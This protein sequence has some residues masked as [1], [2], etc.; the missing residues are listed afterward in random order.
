M[1]WKMSKSGSFAVLVKATISPDPS[2]ASGDQ[3]MGR[4]AVANKARIGRCNR[5]LTTRS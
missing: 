4:Q 1:D 2:A 5:A 3:N